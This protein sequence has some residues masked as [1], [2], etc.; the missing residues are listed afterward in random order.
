MV[1]A[2]PFNDEVYEGEADKVIYDGILTT[3]DDPALMVRV[4]V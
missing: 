2:A 1:K 4:R 3:I